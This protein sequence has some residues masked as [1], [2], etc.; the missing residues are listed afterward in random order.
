VDPD[1][2]LGV[3]RRHLAPEAAVREDLVPDD[4]FLTVRR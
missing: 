2:L 1:W 3:A 4:V